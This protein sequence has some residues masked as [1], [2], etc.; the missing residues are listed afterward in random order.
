[1]SS[2]VKLLCGL[3]ALIIVVL[4]IVFATAS[5]LTAVERQHK[6]YLEVFLVYLYTGS[7]LVLL[8]F[9]VVLLRGVKVKNSYFETNIIKVSIRPDGSIQ[10]SPTATPT[11][12]R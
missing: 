11:P 2:L 5:S 12:H 8:Y 7:L 6:Y 9:Q 1:M 4:G 10:K 3:Y